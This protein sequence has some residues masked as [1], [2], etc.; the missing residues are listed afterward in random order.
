MM[1]ESPG[2]GQSGERCTDSRYILKAELRD[3]LKYWMST[4]REKDI[5][6]E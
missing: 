5:I 1:E 2:P 6:S 4:V 3:F